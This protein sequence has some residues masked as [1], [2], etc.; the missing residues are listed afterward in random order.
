MKIIISPA[1][2]ISDH[3]D[4]NYPLSSL[5]IL[6]K[7]Q[8]LYDLLNSLTLNELKEVLKTSDSITLKTYDNLKRYQLKDG[9]LN[10]VLAY[11]GIQ[12]QYMT[13]SIL[14]DDELLYLNEH[15][16]II[17]GLYGY[18]RPFDLI[19]PHRLEMQS[20]INDISLYDYWA[21]DIAKV[22]HDDIIIDL[23]SKEYSKAVLPHIKDKSR[24]YTI[25]FKE[26][27]NHKL[28]EKGVYVKMARGAM[29]R[30]MANNQIDSIEQIKN[31]NEL[32][33][34]YREEYSDDHHLIFT[35]KKV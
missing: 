35:R 5:N 12:Y 30:Y 20:I 34:Q 11:E 29:V 23:A 22:I 17:N 13:P 27:D 28:I 18:N 15:L 14:S 1:K 19:I 6:P 4:F 8:K 7:A 24:I 10:A 25:S 31:F 32:N 26:E 9:Y 3:N 2:K 33:Y 16:L 21:D